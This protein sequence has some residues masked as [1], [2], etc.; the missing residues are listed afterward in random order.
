MRSKVWL[1]V[2]LNGTFIDERDSLFPHSV[3]T[4]VKEGLECAKAGAAIVHFHP[5]NGTAVQTDEYALYKEILDGLRGGTDAILYGTLTHIGTKY[6]PH[7]SDVSLRFEP[8][9]RLAEEGLVDWL[10]S[11][12][13]SV[14]LTSR[15]SIESD[16]SGT[17]YLNP[18]AHFLESLRIAATHSVNPSIAVF[19][20]GFIRM[21]GA[22]IRQTKNV[23]PPIYR[24]MFSDDYT[25]GLPPR[26]YAL[27]TYLK[28]LGDEVGDVPW[29]AAGLGHDLRG[30]IPQI[31]ERG[32][33]VRV[34]LEDA[35]LAAGLRNIE[36]VEQARKII[37]DQGYELA[38]PEEVRQITA[39]HRAT[40]MQTVE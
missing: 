5:Y 16:Q 32:G 36:W 3:E 25:F 35:P 29:I 2:A 21:A 18:D 26:E 24:F 19:E 7:V 38:S 28:L 11:D 9:R 27:D 15:R 10:V 6:A 1:E 30:L 34:G 13:A 12:P 39:S 31:L 22:W 23:P 37:E 17:V 33:G 40:D 4:I 8:I 14:N 20:P